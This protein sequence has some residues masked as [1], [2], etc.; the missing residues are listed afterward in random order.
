MTV[1]V[2]ANTQIMRDFA[3]EY[4]VAQ[5]I[6]TAYLIAM[7]VSQLLLGAFSDQF[8]RRPIMMVGLGIFIAGSV[9]CAIA[10]SLEVLLLGRAVQ[11]AG[12]SVGIAMSRA[13]VRDVYSRAKSASVIGYI[14]MAMVIA[15]MVGPAI[16]G[17][18][19]QHSSWRFIFWFLVFAALV[20]LFLVLAQLNETLREHSSRSARP[21]LLPSAR[22]LLREPTFA[23]YVVNMAF[24]AGMFFAF[25]AGAPYLVMEVMQRSPSEYGLY[26]SI[27]AFGYLC[28]NFVSGRHSEAQ[29]PERMMAMA[30]APSSIGLAL[31]WL[32]YGSMHPL[33]LF[34]PMF[35]IA[36]SN[37][38]TIPNSTAAA[39][40]VRPDLA[41]AAS[42]ISGALQI[43]IGAALS[44]IVGFA[45]NGEFWPLLTVMTASGIVSALG[46]GTAIRQLKGF[47]PS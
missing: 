37:G 33:A 30:L 4:G 23:S 9:I 36:F 21:G 39:L 15:P 18:L 25:L 7:A 41:G 24:A 47:A 46:I 35:F 6:L 20:L 2:P 29:G 16:G 1:A 32:L 45:Q 40:S 8:G 19:T 44:V 31:F 38:L 43:G 28:G 13:I 14:S 12:G 11:G 10:P 26:F 17:T 22:T 42:G 27:T 5:L 34:I 3:T